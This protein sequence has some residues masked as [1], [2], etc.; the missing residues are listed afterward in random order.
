MY[1][2]HKTTGSV[3]SGKIVRLALL[4][5]PISIWLCG[6]I[7]AAAEPNWKAAEKEVVQLLQKLIRTDTQN[8]PGNELAAC[9]VLKEFFDKEGISNRIYRVE[10]GRANLVARLHGN[11]S[12]KPILLVAH[13]DV[14]PFDPQ[15]WSVPP[16][17]GEIREGYLYGRGTLDVKGLLAV[18]AMTLALLKRQNI[19]LQRD[20]V[21]LATAAEETGG[22]IGVGWMLEKHREELEAA[23][24][25]NEGGRIVLRDGQPLYIGIQTEEKAAYNIKLIARGTSGHASVPRLDNPIFALAEALRR[26]EGHAQTQHLDQVT[27]TF[28]QGIAPYDSTVRWVNGQVI[29]DNPVYLAFLN[30]SLSPTM[31]EGGLKSNVIPPSAAVVLNCRLLPDQNIDE[32]VDTLR[33]WVGPGPY[34]FEYAA[35]GNPPP[36]SSTQSSGFILIEQVCKQM[37]PG[38]PVLP[39]LSPGASDGTRLRRAGIPTY[40]L[41]PFPAK[42]EEVGRIHGKDERVSVEALMM[43]LKL[44][45][46]V[47][48]LAGK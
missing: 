2:R 31:L 41:L 38:A 32:F 46:A 7:C 19:P 18:E 29:T 13:T 43:G 48:E 16:L 21:L 47:A 28:F 6:T 45:Y 3:K 4:A 24:A 11:G 40:G 5:V 25:L 27:R 39:Y 42:E 35:R 23:F 26:L 10:K 44:V 14:V 12:S 9:R 1:H 17:S 36:P 37:F 30:N 34:E 33:A 22:G 15:E 8:P 20:I